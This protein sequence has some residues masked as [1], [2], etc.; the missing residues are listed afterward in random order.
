M[1]NV[2]SYISDQGNCYLN[3]CVCSELRVREKP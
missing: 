3:E 1:E 2:Y